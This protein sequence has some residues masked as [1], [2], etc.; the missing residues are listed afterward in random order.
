[1]EYIIA[2]E[3]MNYVWEGDFVLD[4]KTVQPLSNDDCP[5]AIDV[6]P[7][8]GTL[9]GTTKAATPSLQSSTG[10]ISYPSP[11]LWYRIVGSG[12]TT[13]ASLCSAATTYDSYIEVYQA[14]GET[15]NQTLIGDND[16][17]CGDSSELLWFAAKGVTYYIRVAGCYDSG[18]FG[19]TVTTMS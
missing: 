16:D 9:Y 1:V 11:D 12:T 17:S 10:S 14:E 18:P 19:L 2:I 3:A 6:Q 13:V 15:C 4:V 8:N 7:N 5:G